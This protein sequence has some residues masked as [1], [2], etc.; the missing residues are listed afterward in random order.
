MRFPRPLQPVLA[1]ILA[2]CV[3]LLGLAASA[4]AL[5][6]VICLS[7]TDHPQAAHATHGHCDHRDDAP[8][9]DTTDH[10][11]AITLFAAGC[12]SPPPLF[13]L[14]EPALNAVRVEHLHE[15]LLARTLRGPARVCG[16]PAQA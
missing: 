3:L 5:H 4:P 9:P 10:A 7:H 1:A 11:C 12:D 15:L 2:A 16:P 13:L 8:A 14:V 6:A